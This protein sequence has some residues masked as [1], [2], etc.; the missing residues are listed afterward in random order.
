MPINILRRHLLSRTVILFLGLSLTAA[1]LPAADVATMPTARPEAVGLSSERLQRIGRVMDQHVQEGRIPGAVG[2]IARRG[3]VAYFETWGFQDREA[4]TPMAEDTV[5]RIYSMSKAITAVAVMVLHEEHGFP[6]ETPVSRWLP[7]LGS[8]HVVVEG[9]DPETG[10]RSFQLEPA[11]RDITVRDLLTHT[12]GIG[13]V[14]PR[15]QRGELIYKKLGL[16]FDH[17]S[18]MAQSQKYT[19]S[20][21]VEILGKAPL[22]NHPGAAWQ[23]GYSTDV[24]GRLV[25]VISGERFDRYLENHLF[26]PLGMED[27]AFYVPEGK[28]ERLAV[29]YERD[30]EGMPLRSTKPDQDQYLNE[31]KAFMGGQGLVSTVEDYLRFCQMLLNGGELGGRRILGRKSVELMTSDH[32]GD[33]PR[34]GL[35]SALDAADGFGFTFQIVH[36]PGVHGSLGSPG[37]YGWGGAANRFWIDPEEETVVIFLMQYHDLS[38]RE[39]FKN[40]VYQA[41]ID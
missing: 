13:Y 4:K 3:R 20:E 29:L 14:G 33:L 41:I 38:Y 19:L 15:D 25:E 35:V 16:G 27:T 9:I 17:A 18:V 12:S 31:P 6:L 1:E 36:S 24:L 40:L 8:L 39:Q 28:R 26:Q 5:F 22:Q 21:I 23:Y 30:D 10:E 2:L 34:M 11:R 32:I 37:M 7:E